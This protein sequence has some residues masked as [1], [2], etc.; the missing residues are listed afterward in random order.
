MYRNTAIGLCACFVLALLTA[1]V[2]AGPEQRGKS[3]TASIGLSPEHHDDFG[4]TGRVVQYKLCPDDDGMID[5]TLHADNLVPRAEHTIRSGGNVI[6][7][8]TTNPQGRLRIA[9]E[10]HVDDL[11]D[12]FNVWGPDPDDAD[13]EYRLLTSPEHRIGENCD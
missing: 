2:F 8:G 7:V 4:Q 6:A 3:N 11:G 13:G 10:V 9:A 12:R 1:G 5:F